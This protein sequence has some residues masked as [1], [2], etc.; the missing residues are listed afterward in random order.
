MKKQLALAVIVV[1]LGTVRCSKPAVEEIE[2]TGPLTVA[3]EPARL[4]MIENSLTVTGTVTPSPGADWIL[5][6]PE[7]ARIV[8][9][10]KA[11]GDPVKAGDLLVR[12]EIPSLTA[13]VI[14]SQ[15]E[16]LQANAR[17]TNAKA[18]ATRLKGLVERGIA[19]QRD[20]DDAVREQTE[21]EA[22]VRQAEGGK[23]AADQLVARTVV[24]ARFSGVVAKRFHNPGDTVEATAADPVMRVIDPT[25]LEIT[26]AVPAAQLALITPGHPAK[27]FNPSD[28]S[29]MAGS[30]IT[31]APSVDESAAT[32][33]VR[34]SLGKNAP[35]LTVGTPIQV[36]I[37]GDSRASVLVV[38]SAAIFHEGDLVFVVVAGDDGKAHHKN[39]K[40]GIQTREKT[41]I[42]SGLV[43]GEKVILSGAE[44]VPDG[45]AITIGK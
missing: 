3:V 31:R 19:A 27:I 24:H 7:S 34:I 9:M 22:A 6:A 17:L 39:V 36:E 30:V 26:A 41:Q 13:A 14:S 32:G 33:D 21:A 2:T 38:P 4:D 25:R 11:E 23:A 5:I 12:Y 29:E 40:T 43:A 42:V 20:L 10:P 35:A 18:A 37:T 16:M 1:A 45:A 15:S 28:G 8:D 44:P